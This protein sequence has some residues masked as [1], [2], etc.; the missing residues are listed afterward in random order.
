MTLWVRIRDKDT[1][2]EFDVSIERYEQ[3][4]DKGAAVEELPGRRHEGNP[5]PAKPQRPFRALA[6]VAK[7][8]APRV[9]V[10]ADKKE[11]DLS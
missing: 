8:T 11:S 3:L 6:P 10:V 1:G 7:R 5:E 9:E 4:L 2:H